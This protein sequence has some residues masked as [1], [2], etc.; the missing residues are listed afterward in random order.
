MCNKLQPKP[1]EILD[2]DD[3]FLYAEELQMMY[4]SYL[5]ESPDYF[6]IEQEK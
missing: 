4:E 1:V 5:S 3:E 6:N 2:T